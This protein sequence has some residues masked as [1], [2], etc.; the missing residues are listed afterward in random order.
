MTIRTKR[1]VAESTIKEAQKEYIEGLVS[2][3]AHTQARRLSKMVAKTGTGYAPPMSYGKILGNSKT[4]RDKIIRPLAERYGYKG[5]AIADRFANSAITFASVGLV[6]NKPGY[7]L[8]DRAA[9]LPKDAFMGMMFAAAGTPTLLG[10]KWGP[11][12]EPVALMA[13]GGFISIIQIIRKKK[14]FHFIDALLQKTGKIGEY[15]QKI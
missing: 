6:S 8:A 5:A 1:L 14:I 3:G 11:K 13:L 12:L 15:D 10:K 9:D 2:K 4:Y 7:S